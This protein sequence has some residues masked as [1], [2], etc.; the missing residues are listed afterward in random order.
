[1]EKTQRLSC[2]SFGPDDAPVIVFLHGGGSAGWMWQPVIQ[3]LREYRCLTPDLPEHG[4]SRL[5]APFSMKLA[6]EKVADLIEDQAPDGKAVVVGLSE[7]AQ[8]AV[9]LLADAPAR[10]RKAVISSALLLP[11]RGLGWMNSPAMFQW[12]HRLFM[13]PFKHNDR[14]IR[15]NM[16]YSAGIPEE[17]FEFFKQD[18]QATT[19]EAFVHLMV[20]NQSFRLPAG[21]E[22]AAAPTLALAGEKEYAAMRQS[23]RALAAALPHA[24][25]GWVEL[26]AGS[27]LAEQHNWAVTAPERFAETVRCWVEDRPLPA[28]IKTP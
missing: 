25:A 18:F 3:H 14:W 11:M 2:R 28:W 6:A 24:R 16:K 26:G 20:A 13:A 15:L 4:T 22:N 21:L 9:Q 17:Y 10:V 5:I 19:E 1:M 23:A 7:G 27:S 8:V 12:T